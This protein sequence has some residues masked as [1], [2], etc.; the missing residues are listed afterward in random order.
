MAVKNLR[1]RI[2]AFVAGLLLGPTV[3]W[4]G[5]ES[6]TYI[7][8][9]VASNPLS[10]DLASTA[11]D[12]IRLLKS[13]IKTTF[14]NINNAVTVTDEQ[15]NTISG[16]TAANPSASIGLS[17]VNGTATTYLRSDGAPALS[18]AIAPTWTDVHTFT[19]VP[20]SSIDGSVLL[21]DSNNPILAMRQSGA[22]A[23]NKVWDFVISGEALLLRTAN[24]LGAGNANI[25][26][27]D[28]TGTTV[29]TVAFPTD[30]TGAFRVGTHQNTLN[31]SRMVVR[32]A[33]G[34]NSAAQF[35][36]QSATSST[37]FVH[38]QETSGDNS[39]ITFLTEGTTGT[40]RGSIDYNRA[41]GEVRYNTTSDERLKKNIRPA[42]SARDLI[43]CIQ[44]FGYDWRE[45]GN[46]VDHGVT[47][48][49]LNRCAP[50]AVT[51]GK[52]WQ[53]DKSA[54]IPALI[55]YVQEQ[56]ARIAR[57]EADAARRH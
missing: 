25:M 32:T 24:D 56:D 50:Y 15:L 35:V 31:G 43:G 4:A 48:Q 42:K 57:L 53:V 2:V 51:R 7:S 37:V 41:G 45:T 54:L 22:T 39:F 13:T 3:V 46:H 26:R 29:D 30:S 11:D 1:Q 28:R 19:N 20:S 44:I 34:S 8:D 38:N 23:D 27:V 6:A 33:N 52:V 40:T 9:L 12:H 5:L 10:S 21:T 36:N 16:I 49:Q 47:A 55:K 18:Q 17:A 14:P